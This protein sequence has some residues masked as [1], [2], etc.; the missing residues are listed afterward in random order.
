MEYLEGA[1]S[2]NHVF[3]KLADAKQH[4]F[5]RCIAERFIYT[6][7]IHI[8]VYKE[9]HGDLHP[10]NVM[11]TPAGK[12]YLIDWGNSIKL[13]GKWKPFWN[14]LRA[15]L[16]ANTVLL[17]DAII[18]I[19]THPEDNQRRWNEIHQELENTLKHKN[20]TPLGKDFV[21]CLYKEGVE[22]LYKRMQAALHLLSNTQRLGVI[23]KSEYLHLSR[24]LLALTG[25]YANLCEGLPKMAIVIDICKTLSH[26]PLSLAGDRVRS[27]RAAVVKQLLEKLPFALFPKRAE[28]IA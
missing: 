1:V 7:L 6:L 5:R 18:A 25:T 11:V 4:Q 2:I 27:K 12:I 24:S 23:V 8:F 9:F 22:G 13:R 14:Y 17:T 26:F 3:T 10:G 15:V 16:A 19:S 20:L 21:S 28:D